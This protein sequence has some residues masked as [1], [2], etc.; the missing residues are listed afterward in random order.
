M[1][2]SDL[3]KILNIPRDATKIDIKK[4]YKKLVLVY[5]PDKN[6]SPYAP[7]MFRKIQIAYETLMDNEKRS[8]Y[9]R[10][11]NN[12]LQDIF[13][14]YHELIQEIC[15]KYKLTKADRDEIINLFDP[16]DFKNELVTN[17][18]ESIYDK[19]IDKLV[20]YLSK[21]ILRKISDQNIYLGTALS[22]VYSLFNQS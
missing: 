10:M 12:Q 17:D 9:D 11:T 21:F 3:Y 15:D 19:L 8:K 6:H 1:E 14:N 16:N 5:H 13:M 2:T 4:S 18:M 20:N 22:C 7:E